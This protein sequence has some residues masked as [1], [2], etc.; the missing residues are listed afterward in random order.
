MKTRFAAIAVMAVF[1]V[2]VSSSAVA[3]AFESDAADVDYSKYYYSQLD[4]NQKAIYDAYFV[5]ITGNPEGSAGSYQYNVT[6]GDKIVVNE[7]NALRAWEACRLDNPYA[8]WTW[9]S[10][11]VVPSD[12]IDADGQ[13]ITIKTEDAYSD[14]SDKATQ[15]KNA[16]DA[17]DIGDG[18]ES[19]RVE[20]INSILKGKSY[21]YDKNGS[22]N[23][24][25]ILGEDTHTLSA[26][27]FAAVFKALC[28]RDVNGTKVGCMQIYGT[29]KQG[30]TNTPYAWNAV[31][32]DGQIYA[33]DAATNNSK[34]ADAWLCVGLYTTYGGNSFGKEH[35][36]FAFNSSTGLKYDFDSELLCNDGYEWPKDNSLSAL[37]LANASWICIGAICVVLAIALVM[38]ARKEA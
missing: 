10:V 25:G 7:Y 3:F 35:A 15:A 2:L 11:G 9:T 38:M 36:A 18:N 26:E 6:I 32:I 31:S 17:I 21:K 8:F 33:V 29:L 12:I 34:Q 5:Q 28:D 4:E 1:V 13:K 23:V 16:I 19:K 14:A 27:G 30:S 22:A 37:I 20:K 24:S